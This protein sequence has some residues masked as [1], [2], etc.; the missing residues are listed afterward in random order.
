MSM[1][2]W[3]S[4]GTIMRRSVKVKA[5]SNERAEKETLTS[6]SEKP[7]LSGTNLEEG[8]SRGGPLVLSLAT[9]FAVYSQP[10]GGGS[11]FSEVSWASSYINKS[12][13]R[14]RRDLWQAVTCQA[15]LNSAIITSDHGGIE[16]KSTLDSTVD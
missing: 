6:Q 11:R 7:A 13:K 5:G 16:S 10:P 3:V 1:S 14:N 2:Q 15:S 9:T 8:N 12:W 4:S